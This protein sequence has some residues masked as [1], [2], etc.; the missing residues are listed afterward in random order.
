MWSGTASERVRMSSNWRRERDEFRDLL[1]SRD[2]L[3]SCE[4]TAESVITGRLVQEDRT[5]V[6]S[7]QIVEDRDGRPFTTL[8]N[9]KDLQ[10]EFFGVDY[11]HGLMIVRIKDNSPENFA[12]PRLYK[13]SVIYRDVITRPEIEVLILAREGQYRNWYQHGK[14]CC[15]PS[16][17]C[18][19]ELGFKQVKT[20]QFLKEYWNSADAIVDAIH[21]YDHLIGDHKHDQLNLSD[22]LNK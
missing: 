13:D 3:F 2:V 22:L 8:R 10:R 20:Y 11:P 7:S 19:R 15:K 9:I 17:W 1:Q 6:P 4:G 14:T 21:E 5:L 12:I 18:E 16:E